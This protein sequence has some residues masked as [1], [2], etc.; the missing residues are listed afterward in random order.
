MPVNKQTIAKNTFMLYIRMILVMAAT[1]FTTRI[2]LKNLG[3]EDYGIYNVVAG[4]VTM[5]AF[6]N[7]SMSGATQ[8]FLTFELGLND[9]KRVNVV[10]CQSVI[11]HIFIAVI[12]FLLAETIGLWFVYN[13]LTI[14]DERFT[15]AMWVYQLAILS[16][17]FTVVNVPYQAS[18]I[19]HEDMSVYA[20]GSILDV[21]LKLGIAYMISISPYDKL[22]SY[23]NLLLLTTIVMFL[24]Y[25]IYCK[26]HYM[27]CTFRFLFENEKFSEMFSFAGWNIIGNLSF[28]LRSQGSNILLNMFFGP[29][30]NAARGVA[31]QVEG[32]VEHFVL[33]F[34]TASN[35]QIIKSYA[36]KEY[37]ESIRLVCQCSKFS[38]FLMITIGVPLF[39]QADYILS[40]WLTDVP[41]Y[42]IIFVNLILLSGIVDSLSK[43]LITYIKATGNVKWYQIIQG[44]FYILTLPVIYVFL[45]LGHSPISS[46]MIILVFTVVGTFL[47]LYLV[48]RVAG[49]FSVMFFVRTVL[50][51]AIVVGA[52]AFGVCYLISAISS[53]VNFVC[54]LYNTLVMVI[55]I[56]AILWLFGMNKDE[57]LYVKS[58]ALRCLYLKKHKKE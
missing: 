13:K 30:V 28:A 45:K 6:L 31:Q 58:A 49:E 9:N 18:I 55:L 33:N 32:A 27:E 36:I 47:R 16:F 2:V 56:A 46:M 21:A 38:F 5:F 41:E 43:A 4:I 34:Q 54:L 15:A 42:T 11:I 57:R 39:F 48:H 52:M 14:P 44:G 40:V 37:D 19:A 22:I 12:I 23:S 26:R 29:A 24:F 1:L 25:M 51:P 20:W 53:T 50:L 35:P 3:I 8:R 7:S 10:F 17:L